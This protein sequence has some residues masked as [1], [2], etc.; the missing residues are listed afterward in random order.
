[1][2][3]LI[4]ED[5]Y[6]SRIM[7]KHIL[8]YAGYEV[9][10]ACDGS[11]ALKLLL[12]PDAPMLAIID[13][14]M[15]EL[16]GLEVCRQI[17]EKMPQEQP[18][19]IILTSRNDN[20][21]VVAGLQAG[22]NDFISKPYNNDALLAR[23][24]VGRRMLSMQHALAERVKELESAQEYI[25]MIQRILSICTHCHKIRKDQ[26]NWE[27]LENYITEHSDIQFSHGICPECMEKY[28]AVTGSGN[29]PPET[30]NQPD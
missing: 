30:G 3:L 23:L 12:E 9:I 17:R 15:P 18:Y 13:W 26:T 5:D 6:T 7:L 20:S 22:A 14:I 4:A 28:Y 29:A 21:D 27:K 10:E 19:L 11:E 16:D 2:K 25:H 8:E 1:M 24:D